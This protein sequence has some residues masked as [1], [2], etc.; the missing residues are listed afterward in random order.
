VPREE[1]DLVRHFD[2]SE[3][4]DADQR[5]TLED[6]ESGIRAK[7]DLTDG[8]LLH[9]DYVAQGAGRPTF[10]LLSVHHLVV[11]G[12]SFAILFQDLERAYLQLSRGEPV[13]LPPKTTSVRAWAQRL[14][15]YAQSQ[16][17]RNELEYWLAVGGQRNDPLPVDFPGG[18]SSK[19]WGRSVVVAL[20]ADETS[21]LVRDVPIRTATQ[22][23]DILLSGIAIGLARWT[24]ST[25]HLMDLRS[26]GRE[27]LS[28]DVDLSRT[29]GWFTTLFPIRLDIST[30]NADE[31]LRRISEQLRRVPHGGIGFGVLRDL[32][33][34]PA[35]EQSM[36][37]LP[38]P[39]VSINYVGRSDELYASQSLFV[40]HDAMRPRVSQRPRRGRRDIE[41]TA[42][43]RGGQFY[44]RFYYHENVYRQGTIARVAEDVRGTLRALVA[45]HQ[46]IA[47]ARTEGASVVSNPTGV[48]GRQVE[49][50]GVVAD[51]N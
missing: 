47:L 33:G 11:D 10:L 36:R 34:D 44:L 18:L 14:T 19:G 28:E 30:A 40:P 6:L 29:V 31:A 21:S 45:A 20:D 16:E 24:G 25:S 13:R 2:L 15:E 12:Y 26:H 51:V 50:R 22:V 32:T 46:S 23:E 17:L 35:M 8:P 49:I 1:H 3:L 42:G 41:I 38:H 39:E 48:N 9:V 7:L 27:A 37:E 4:S 5:A 43:V